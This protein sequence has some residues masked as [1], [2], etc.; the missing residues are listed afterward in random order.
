MSRFSRRASHP[1]MTRALNKLRTRQGLQWAGRILIAFALTSALEGAGAQTV[2]TPSPI[3]LAALPDSPGTCHI[4]GAIRSEEGGAV[5]GSHLK[6]MSSDGRTLAESVTLGDGDYRWDGLGVGEYILTVATEGFLPAAYRIRIP[7]AGG[8]AVVNVFLKIA[9]V[10]D[11]VTVTASEKEVA[12]AELQLQE[13][14]RLLGIVPN[15]FVSYQWQV[16]HLTSGQKFGLAYKTASDPGNLLLVGTTAGVQQALNT[17]PGYGQGTVGYSR[18][19][20]ADLGNL[21]VGT[22]MGGAVFP[23]LFHQDPR[24]FYRGSGTVRSR[25][26]YAATRAVVTRGDNGRPQP[27]WSGMLGDISAG[28]MSNLYYA[29]EDRNG[30]RLTLINGLLGIGGDAMNGIVQ[31]FLL[32]RFTTHTKGRNGKVALDQFAKRDLDGR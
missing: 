32:H 13:E 11:S 14:Q 20:G 29:P 23:S 19:F 24:Y 7:E 26:W 2:A 22:F 21:V 16:S 18:R 15:F 9:P 3:H 4:R 30:V 10:T 5:S 27:N 17:F 12:E 6:L 28:A 31:E 8:T 1:D 25:F